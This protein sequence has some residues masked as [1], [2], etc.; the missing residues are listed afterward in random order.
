[1]LGHRCLMVAGGSQERITQSGPRLITD[2]SQK[3][4]VEKESRKGER[5]MK[6]GVNE[7]GEG[8]FRFPISK[9]F[10]KS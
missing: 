3:K 4:V 2:G 9:Q 5:R 7:E 10:S 8:E 6:F 1:M